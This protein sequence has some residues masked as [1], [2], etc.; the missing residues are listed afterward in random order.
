M[1][2][3]LLTDMKDMVHSKQDISG[4]RGVT[5][6]EFSPFGMQVVFSSGGIWFRTFLSIFSIWCLF[7]FLELVNIDF[8]RDIWTCFVLG[9]EW[10]HTFF[11]FFFL[12]FFFFLL[13]FFFGN[14]ILFYLQWTMSHWLGFSR[15]L[16]N[17]SRA[18]EKSWSFSSYTKASKI[19][20]LN[21]LQN[22]G[23]P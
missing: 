6:M 7:P 13:V 21:S 2:L 8:T 19:Y 14:F 9:D 20:D 15:G 5:T 10:F 4:R 1:K 23:K 11:S 22:K 17:L 18:G 3:W 16:L 12:F